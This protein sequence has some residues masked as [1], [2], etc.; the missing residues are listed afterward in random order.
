MSRK[1]RVQLG[2]VDR[3]TRDRLGQVE[4]DIRV[5]AA[6]IGGDPLKEPIPQRITTNTEKVLKNGNG[7]MVVLGR[8]RPRSRMSGYGGRGD[9]QAAA[10]D[11]IA[12]PQG[13]QASEFLPGGSRLW[14]DP[15]FEKDAARV[16]ISQKTDVDDNF[17]LARGKVG[18]A[19]TKSAVAM[20]A[21]HV[22]LIARE[23]IK[24]ITKTDKMNSQGGAVESITGIDLIAGNDDKDLQPMSKGKNL[25]K[26][27]RRMMH[28]M[29]KLNGI[30]DSLLMAQMTFNTAL[31]HHFHFSPFFG[32]PT[33]PS[34]PVMAAG[35]KTMINHL[36]QTK[37]SLITHKAN[38]AMMKHTYFS[39]SGGKYINSRYHNLN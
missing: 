3:A 25:A 33:T 36:F 5:R 22:R 28:H 11:I 34:P 29:D 30:V 1:P 21:D 39:P 20:K 27:L 15:D 38:M 16:Y 8:D 9:T 7:A 6:G 13:F 37:R 31:T 17:G 12:G 10:I 32:L 14:V 24:L 18:N 2:G 23:G 35:M 4:E 26:A 19:K